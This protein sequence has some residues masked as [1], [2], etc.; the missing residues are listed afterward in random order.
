MHCLYEDLP[1]LTL[2]YYSTQKCMYVE[3]ILHQRA[4]HM[5]GWAPAFARLSGA[6]IPVALAGGYSGA[7]TKF[8]FS[9]VQH[10]LLS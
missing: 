1:L 6:V 4:Q 2:F 7:F 8:Y 10:N 3:Q 5:Q 9:S